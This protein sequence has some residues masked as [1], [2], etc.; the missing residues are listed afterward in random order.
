MKANFLSLPRE[1]NNHSEKIALKHLITGTLQKSFVHKQ[2][3]STVLSFFEAL[4]QNFRR[5]SSVLEEAKIL[6]LFF[7][8]C[9]A[10]K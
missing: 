5:R 3:P 6:E 1:R 7:P 8:A 10:L 4:H 2:I 9:K